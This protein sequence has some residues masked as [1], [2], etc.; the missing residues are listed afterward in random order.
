MCG[1]FSAYTH[2][3]HFLCP[4]KPDR[5]S[6]RSSPATAGAYAEYENKGDPTAVNPCYISIMHARAS[7]S[8]VAVRK[9]LI[10]TARFRNSVLFLFHRLPPSSWPTWSTDVG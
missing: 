5:V 4:E 7:Q 6:V 9:P 8:V 3:E 2:N 1:S 10:V